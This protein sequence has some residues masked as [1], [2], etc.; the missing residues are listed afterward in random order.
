MGGV[1]A[2]ALYLKD[3]SVSG[4]PTDLIHRTDEIHLREQNS[5]HRLV[6]VF[7]I[8][9]RTDL[10]GFNVVINVSFRTSENDSTRAGSD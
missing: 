8:L 2:L 9:K 7:A 5:D 1:M 4:F 6:W 3:N 10:D